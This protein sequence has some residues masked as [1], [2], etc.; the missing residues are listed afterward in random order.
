[1][2]LVF[3]LIIVVVIV[4]AGGLIYWFLQRKKNS[5]ASDSE[6]SNALEATATSIRPR[7]GNGK[8]VDW[9]VVFKLPNH[10]K[11]CANSQQSCSNICA[12]SGCNKPSNCSVWN[13]R[14][15][16]GDRATGECYFY[17]DS[18]HPTL[19]YYTDLGFG[20]LSDDNSPLQ[21][22]ISQLK[23]GKW[24]LWNDQGLDSSCGSPH[25]HSKGAI[26]YNSRGGFILNVSS[27]HWPNDDLQPLGCQTRNNAEYAQHVFCFS[28]SEKSAE[29]WLQSAANAS[30][31]I[32]GS[33]FL[34]TGPFPG[35]ETPEPFIIN[36]L[37]G[38]P[39]TIM[40]KGS[41][42]YYLPWSLVSETLKTGI[43]VASWTSDSPG[44]ASG[45]GD[46][47]R[48]NNGHEPLSQILDVSTPHGCFKTLYSYNHAK[49]AISNTGNWVIFGSM[50]QQNSQ[51]GRGGDFYA[52]QNPDLWA[53]LKG[54]IANST[55]RNT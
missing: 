10:S 5:E 22:T 34:Q 16:A 41:K 36:T 20:C 21:Q 17:A 1:M 2:S 45:W 11:N 12:C 53:S 51:A 8:E 27:P 25:A 40:F 52:F 32:T 4:L 14:G 46:A 13:S 19:R 24:A 9:F 33:S 37:A 38:I 39:I 3:V 47:P 49:W 42:D 44:S 23:N 35:G 26:S 7:N 15:A 30:L 50:N 6:A 48:Y 28:V 43:L 55:P 18:D 54:F 29:N 31:C